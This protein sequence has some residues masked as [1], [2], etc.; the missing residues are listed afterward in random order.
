MFVARGLLRQHHQRHHVR[1]MSS[2]KI[3]FPGAFVAHKVEAPVESAETSKEELMDY[4]KLMY[5]MR[6]MEITCDNEYKA[7]T[8][9]G[10][11]Q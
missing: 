6:R 11:C 2:V 9:R 4:F 5:T 10:F 1:C 3:D 8:I 7:R